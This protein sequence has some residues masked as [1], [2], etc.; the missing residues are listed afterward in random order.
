VVKIKRHYG[1]ADSAALRVARFLLQQG[2]ARMRAGIK[3][4]VK[5]VETCG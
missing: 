2:N 5:Y 1:A 3:S 4:A